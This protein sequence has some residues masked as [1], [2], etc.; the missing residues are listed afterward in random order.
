MTGVQKRPDYY[1]GVFVNELKK[2]LEIFELEPIEQ[3]IFRGVSYDLGFPNLFGGQVLGQALIAAARTVEPERS[4]H[5]FHAYF[6]RPGDAKAPI[7]YQVNCIRDGG[8]FTTRHITAIQHGRPIFDMSASFQL[9]EAGFEHQ[10]SMPADVPPPGD[11][12]SQQELHAD[13]NGRLPDTLV[14]SRPVEIR[15]VIPSAGD[16]EAARS[17][18]WFRSIEPMPADP[19]M[20]QALLAYASDFELLATALLPH[21][22]SPMRGE[23]FGASLDH[24][25]WIHRPFR[26]DDWLLYD[27]HSPNACNGRGLGWGK[28]YSRDGR[29]VAS[30]AQ[31]GLIR[32]RKG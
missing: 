1:G 22:V 31:E 25:L 23:I 2:L 30:V 5:S 12:K 29:L 7:V 10:D 16:R 14:V 11:L 3:N 13:N 4:A 24:A 19:R 32:K 20:H 8:S 26:I 17:R 18:S 9:P 21:S 6:L 28:I 27:R 15:P